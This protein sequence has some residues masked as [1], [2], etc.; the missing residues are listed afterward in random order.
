MATILYNNNQHKVI[1]FSD[2]VKGSGV[3]ANQFLIVDHDRCAVLDPGGEL[4][5]TPLTIE[6]SKLVSLDHVDYVL[7]SHQD[8]DIISSLPRWLIHTPAKVVVSKLWQ[9]FLPHLASSYVT[10]RNNTDIDK[11][12][13]AVDDRGGRIKIGRQP[14]MV[15]PAHFLHS[16]GNFSFYDPVSKILFSGDIGAS[17]GG[18]NASSAVTHDFDGHTQY[19]RT[20]H[21]RYMTS[22]KACRLW[23]NMVR[24]LEVNMIV[25]QHGARFEGPAINSMLNWLENLDCGVDLLEQSHYQIPR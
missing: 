24:D 20:F 19:M 10:S 5:Y 18:G 15:L 8:P 16:V 3:Q 23:V 7:A 9:R 1:L 21:Q 13:L 17:V 2:L 25:P 22:N 4:T 12:I 6:L 14:F 11:R